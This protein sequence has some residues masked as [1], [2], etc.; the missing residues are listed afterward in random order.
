MKQWCCWRRHLLGA[1]CAL[2][3]GAL[4]FPPAVARAPQP[5]PPAPAQPGSPQFRTALRDALLATKEVPGVH[6]VYNFK[7]GETHGVDE[8]SLVIVTLKNGVWT[9]AP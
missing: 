7:P 1:L 6:A 2:L 9:Y 3:V 8:R 4:S 5:A